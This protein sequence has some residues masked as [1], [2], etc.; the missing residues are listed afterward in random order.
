[1]YRRQG[2]SLTIYGRRADLAQDD[3]AGALPT[4]RPSHIPTESCVRETKVV[5]VNGMKHLV[6]GDRPR[7]ARSPAIA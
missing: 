7:N 1:M 6:I 2:T 5:K 4:A 3:F